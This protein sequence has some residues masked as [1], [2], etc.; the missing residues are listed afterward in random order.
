M[1]DLTKNFSRFEFQ[2]PCG[3]CGFQAADFELVKVLQNALNTLKAKHG[4]ITSGIRCEVHNASVGGAP[5]SYHLKGTAADFYF[6]TKDVEE[7]GEFLDRKYPDKYG[8]GIY[9]SWLHLD[10]RPVKAR[11]RG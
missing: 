6:D 10:M 11:W 4:Y 9:R 8:L 7:V 1:G 5:D 3:N 2:C